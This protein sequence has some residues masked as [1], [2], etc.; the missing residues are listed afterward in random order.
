MP[1]PQPSPEDIKSMLSQANTL[2]N[3]IAEKTA[4]DEECQNERAIDLLKTKLDDAKANR[5]GADEMYNNAERDYMI[6]HS[7]IDYYRNVEEKK[8][9]E[10]LQKEIQANIDYFLIG[11]N[12]ANLQ[13]ET[14]KKEMDYLD[15]VKDLLNRNTTTDTLSDIFGIEVSAASLQKDFIENFENIELEKLDSETVNRKIKYEYEKNKNIEFITNILFY[16]Y[17]IVSLGIIIYLYTRETSLTKYTKIYICIFLLLYPFLKYLIFIYD[18]V[19]IIVRF[20]T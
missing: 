8:N 16:V 20:I 7:G 11:L 18:L 9:Q 2:F 14:L 15:L 4:C 12:S 19:M 17:C 6:G 13:V 5:D 1:C 10:K 3:N